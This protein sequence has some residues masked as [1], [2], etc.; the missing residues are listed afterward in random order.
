MPCLTPNPDRL[1]DLV[2]VV[3]RLRD[4]DQG[5]PLKALLRVIAEQVDVVEQD[6]ATLYENWFVETCS[7][8]VV[9]YIGSLI[10]YEPV[11]EAGEPTP[12]AGMMTRAAGRNR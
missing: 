7:E 10:D 8:W 4:A 5:Y 6:I 2:P 12:V 9:P 3:Y 1:Y 11:H